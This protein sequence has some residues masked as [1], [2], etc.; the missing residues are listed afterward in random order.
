MMDALTRTCA[1]LL[2]AFGLAST[3][4]AKRF[5]MQFDIDGMQRK[6]LVY[7]PD[8]PAAGTTPLVI[9]YHGR[10]DDS[11]A[12]ANAVKLHKDWPDVIVAYPRGET[13]DTTPPMRGWQYKLGTYDDRDLKLSDQMLAELGKRYQTEPA[14]TFAAGFSNGGHFVFL[15]NAQRNDQFAAFAAIGALQPEYTSEAPPKP[16]MYLFGRRE[17]PKYLGDWAKTVEA[18]SRHNLSE[19]RA[20]A[21]LDCCKL[22]PPKPGGAPLVFGV[23]NA[24][25]IWPAGGNAWLRE[26]FRLGPVSSAAGS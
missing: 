14:Q 2:L 5:T 18:L 1:I 16:F 21:W 25:H 9:V 12:F 4:D 7:A 10:G 22:L 24:G 8:Q 3:A 13:I 15:L 17:D 20:K 19:E 26:F 6:V 11:V 23:Y